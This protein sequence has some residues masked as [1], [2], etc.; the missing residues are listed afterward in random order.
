MKYL[1]FF[2]ISL[3][4]SQEKTKECEEKSAQP[5]HNQV[6]KE[7]ETN[8]SCKNDTKDKKESKNN[9]EALKKFIK[10]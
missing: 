10:P 4:F 2:L 8:N 1:L 6:L 3:C 7:F 9:L 5:T